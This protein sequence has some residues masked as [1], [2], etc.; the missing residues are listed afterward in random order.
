MGLAHLSFQGG[1][2]FGQ[3]ANLTH[4]DADFQN[5]PCGTMAC[6]LN[7]GVVTFSPPEDS[8]VLAFILQHGG[9]KALIALGLLVPT[10]P[11]MAPF[12]LITLD[13]RVET[14][15]R[16]TF[17]FSLVVWVDAAFCGGSTR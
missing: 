1:D 17:P 6:M 3:F 11:D 4:L 8:Q 7:Q 12:P 10:Y 16:I 15:W 5:S 2:S 14:F 9:A 13:P